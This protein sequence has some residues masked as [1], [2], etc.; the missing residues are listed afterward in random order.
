MSVTT[1]HP[2]MGDVLDAMRSV[3]TESDR[4]NLAE[5][6]QKQVPT[7][8]QGF[9]EIVDA[10]TA[11]GVSGNLSITTL[12]LYR[13]AAVRWPASKRVP[14]VSF[15]AHREAMVLA[16][17]DQAAKMLGDLAKAN[18]ADKVTVSSVRKAIA[19]KQG[20]PTPAPRTTTTPKQQATLDVL[21]DLKNGAPQTIAAITAALPAAELDKLHAGLTK[22]IAHVE[23]LRAKV[24][25]AQK[26]ATP[27]TPA[28]PPTK[29]QSNG[30]KKAPV[31]KPQGDLRGL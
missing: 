26:P 1:K 17:I 29:Q 8:L 3:Q 28:E 31:K 25:R 16:D 14:N 19:V 30:T 15:S 20:K 24:A 22:V 21:G 18:G 27:T 11:A 6:L 5:A 12:R 9:S 7:G 10:A 2:A 23:R 13:D 4:W